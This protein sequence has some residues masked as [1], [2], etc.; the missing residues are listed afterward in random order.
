MVLIN[1]LIYPKGA[2]YLVMG[3]HKRSLVTKRSWEVIT[4]VWPALIKAQHSEKPSIL[5]LIDDIADK[6]HKNV[7]AT[8]INIEVRQ[9]HLGKLHLM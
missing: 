8:E 7:E 1:F 3:G 2:L 4:R 9:I 5:R 6:L